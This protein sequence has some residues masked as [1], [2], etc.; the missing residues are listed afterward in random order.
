MLTTSAHPQLNI[1]HNISIAFAVLACIRFYG[2][3]KKDIK[4]HRP[5]AKF[6]AFKLIVGITFLEQVNMPTPPLLDLEP[7]FPGPSLPCIV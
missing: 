6:L 1:I 2:A 3:L 4:H 5:L 7:L